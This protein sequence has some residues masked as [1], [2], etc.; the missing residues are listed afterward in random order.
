LLRCSKHT[1]YACRLLLLR[2]TGNLLATTLLLLFLLF[3]LLVLL[4]VM[5]LLAV[6]LLPLLQV[7]WLVTCIC[8]IEVLPTTCGMSCTAQP[9]VGL[10]I[11]AVHAAQLVVLTN[12]CYE[13]HSCIY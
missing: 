4:A 10:S 3:L 1:D 6:I 12:C 11:S 8:I 9:P 7:F 2:H 5:L 13:V